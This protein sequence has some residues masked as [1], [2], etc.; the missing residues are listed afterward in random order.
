[1]EKPAA[2]AY[3]WRLAQFYDQAMPF[4][5]WQQWDSTVAVFQS[6][7]PVLPIFLRRNPEC[8][9]L[10][11]EP[12]GQAYF[13]LPEQGEAVVQKYA[14]FPYAVAFAPAAGQTATLYADRS[15]PPALS[16]DGSAIKRQVQ[17]LQ[18]HLAAQPDDVEATR[19]WTAGRRTTRWWRA[20]ARGS[21]ACTYPRRRAEQAKKISAM[22]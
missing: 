7:Q 9:W 10:V 19:S 1:M 20:T 22:V 18:D 11:D 6:G 14:N 8:R 4:A 15:A 21:S 13:V 17:Q 2:P 5:V 12:K 3:A 16:D